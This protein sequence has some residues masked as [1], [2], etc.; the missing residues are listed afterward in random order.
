MVTRT[1]RVITRPALMKPVHLRQRYQGKSRGLPRSQV[2]G[3]TGTGLTGTRSDSPSP[4]RRGSRS[5]SSAP[6]CVQRP[7]GRRRDGESSRLAANPVIQ[8]CPAGPAGRPRCT[9]PPVLGARFCRFGV[10]RRVVETLRPTR[11]TSPALSPA[12]PRSGQGSLPRAPP[13]TSCRTSSRAGRH[14][15]QFRSPALDG[16]MGS[17]LSGRVAVLVCWLSRRRPGFLG[18]VRGGGL[19]DLLDQDLQRPGRRDGQ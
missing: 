3:W 15:R 6:W 4:R 11:R 2:T 1:S 10:G 18:L 8:A 12:T 14:G 5:T 13:G 7:L 17:V 16:R 9:V 19:P